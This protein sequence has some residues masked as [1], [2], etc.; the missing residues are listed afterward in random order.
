[1]V[2]PRGTRG[3]GAL[4]PRVT[5]QSLAQPLVVATNWRGAGAVWLAVLVAGLGLAGIVYRRLLIAHDPP[6]LPTLTLFATVVVALA[7][8]MP[9]VFSSDVYAYAAYGEL[10][11]RGIDPYV[12]APVPTH[13]EMLSLAIWQW[14][15]MLPLCVYG[16]AF[17]GLSEFIVATFARFGPRPVLDTLRV[18]ACVAAL[19]CAPL[20]YAAFD[21]DAR[22]KRLAAT[23]IVANPVTLWCAAEGH[24]DALA[25]A[26]VLAG[27]ALARRGWFGLGAMVAAFSALVKLPGIVGALAL[28]TIERRT[29]LPGALAVGVTLCFCLPLFF[30][31]ATTVAPQGRYAPQASLQGIVAPFLGDVAAVAVALLAGAAMALRGAG[32]LRRGAWDGWIW[33]GLGAWTLVP[34]PYPW[35]S[36]WLLAL[37][38]IAPYSRAGFVAILVSFASL[39][40]Y[41]PDAIA[42]LSGAPAV[43]LSVGASLPLSLLLFE[44]R[45]RRRA[46]KTTT[47]SR[48]LTTS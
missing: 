28:A 29:R 24:N 44:P 25:L 35:Y 12:R 8:C 31:I 14:G 16:P 4:R 1:M 37:A 7:W 36:I 47:P 48:S 6:G 10:A 22:A 15:G 18:A 19:A 43:V 20:T 13:G 3:R 21:G 11:G 30:G 33:L 27:F 23:V 2:S 46:F 9:V 41:V 26:V 5:A 42:P 34:N 38:A 17:V 39:L 45:S 40:R 32:K